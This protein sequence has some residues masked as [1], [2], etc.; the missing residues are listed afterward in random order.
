[1]ADN[2]GVTYQGTGKVEVEDIDYP[3]FEL[4]AGPGVPP[5]KRRAAVSPRGD[6]ENRPT[7]ICGIDS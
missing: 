2:R 7:N 6:P 3:S 4:K 5:D 1:M